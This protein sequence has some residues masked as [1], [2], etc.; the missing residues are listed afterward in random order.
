[1]ID[2]RLPFAEIEVACNTCGR[3]VLQQKRRVGRHARYC[4]AA[5]KRV[6]MREQ[7]RRAGRRYYAKWGVGPKSGKAAQPGP[8]L[9]SFG[10][11]FSPAA[12]FDD[13]S[14]STEGENP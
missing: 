2:Q 5:C 6:A 14:A 8:A 12:N 4:S 11:F 10:P 7:N 1:M 9:P 13:P 3:M